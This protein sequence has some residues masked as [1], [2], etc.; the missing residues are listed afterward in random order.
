[1]RFIQQDHQ[2]RR[3]SP[4][5]AGQQLHDAPRRRS[6]VGG[7]P[8]ARRLCAGQPRS[9]HARALRELVPEGIGISERSRWKVLRTHSPPSDLVTD[10]VQQGR[11]A[12]PPRPEEQEPLRRSPAALERFQPGVRERQFRVPPGQQRRMRAGAGLE[13]VLL[14]SATHVP[15]LPHAAGTGGV[16][17]RSRSWM[18]GRRVVQPVGLAPTPACGRLLPVV[19][20]ASRSSRSGRVSR[21]RAMPAWRPAFQAGLPP[22]AGGAARRGAGG[23]S[24]TIALKRNLKVPWV[25]ARCWARKPIITIVPSPC[26]ME[27]MAAFSAIASSPSS[28]PLSRMSLSR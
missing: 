13:R 18:P 11:L 28:Q 9:R 10:G 21:Y 23:Y 15:S 19:A 25:W 2:R 27:T 24:P 3:V 22:R 1:M 5:P 12:V 14:A 17:G 20:D 8:E 7:D 16:R 4:D 6:G 26:S